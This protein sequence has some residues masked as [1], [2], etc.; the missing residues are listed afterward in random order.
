MTLQVAFELLQATLK[1]NED[2][3]KRINYISSGIGQLARLIEDLVDWASIEQGKFRLEKN[4]FS[5]AKMV[6]ETLVGPQA[7]ASQRN[8]TLKAQIEP[9]LPLIAADKKRLS[10]VLGNLLENALRHTPSGGTILVKV[11]HLNGQVRFGVEDTGEGI[12][13]D[14]LNKIFHSFYQPAGSSRHGRLG[15]GLS[16]AQEIVQSHEGRIWV[17]SRGLG[18]GAAFYFTVPASVPASKV[19]K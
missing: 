1:P 7:K 5:P 12:A 16:I 3:K 2:Q 8:I 9:G 13:A 6:E 19:Q 4:F 17:Q 10:Q 15:L 11:E 18:Q 14:E